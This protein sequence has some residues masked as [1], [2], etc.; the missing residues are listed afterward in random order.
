MLHPCYWPEVRRGS[1]RFIHD[2][3]VRLAARGNRPRL[4]T[5]HPGPTTES[6]EDGID[7]LRLHRPRGRRFQLGMRDQYLTHVPA[8]I[9]ALRRS[10][11]EVVHA[12]YPVDAVAA[13]SWSRS[14]RRPLVFSLMGMPR[15]EALRRRIWRGIVARAFSRADATVCLSRRAAELTWEAFGVTPRVIHPGVDLEVFRP[16]APRAAVPTVLCP[17]DLDDPR[18]GG[19]L[20]REAFR[21]LRGREP[22]ARLI[23]SRPRGAAPARAG[24]PGV[25]YVDLDTQEALVRAYSE[26]WVTV[27]LSRA[28]AFG[29]VLTESLACGTPVLASPG[30]GADEVVDGDPVARVIDTEEPEAVARAIAASMGEGEDVRAACIE[31]ATRFSADRCAEAYEELYREL[32]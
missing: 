17:A 2:L 16:T 10:D 24:E 31:R 21:V 12:L 13:S 29:L 6:V 23:L 5:S 4:I 3:G 18:K 30:G 25:E 14:H 8:M 19:P 26:A 1:E 20:L 22:E 15:P 7:V 9:R 32:V 11:P 28:E 27:L